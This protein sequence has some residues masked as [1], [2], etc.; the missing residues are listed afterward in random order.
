MIKNKVS[1]R[2]ATDK[3]SEI[4]DAFVKDNDG[5]F[6]QCY[7]WRFIYEEQ[8]FKTFYLIAND[9]GG[10][11]GVFPFVKIPMFLNDSIHSMPLG[12][13]SGGPLSKSTEIV[14]A[15]VGRMDEIC[16][17]EK[18]VYAHIL[19]NP[20]KDNTELIKHCKS[21]G[22]NT[23][24]TLDKS[25]HIF[26]LDAKDYDVA[27]KS[28]DRMVRKAMRK[29][30]KEGVSII[31]NDWNLLDEYYSILIE[32]RKKIKTR[33]MDK[34]MFYKRCNLF[35][36][37]ID[38]YIAVYKGKP[39]AG[40]YCFDFNNIRYLFDNVSISKYMKYRP[41]N[42]LYGEAIKDGCEK[43]DIDRIDF[44][45]TA[46]KSS[47][48]RWKKQY[49]GTPVPLQYYEKTYSPVKKF[50]REKTVRPR[51]IIRKLIWSKLVSQEQV[52]EMS[53]KMRKFLE[54]F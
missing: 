46:P 36:D 53:P 17:R 22:Y 10:I 47:Y 6:Y 24:Y 54:W 35:R 9:E 30:I 39:I 13:A 3:D 43:S 44:G 7:K 23:R 28:F 51:V 18:A 42:L 52:N 29:A 14:T 48:F 41:N 4:W 32:N 45:S 38:L 19:V 49:G 21:V 37:C 20:Y 16:I 26:I 1:I 34:K 25:P 50:L 40:M 12:G 11:K 27:W 33:I 5:S 31:K 15:L 2:E 8:G